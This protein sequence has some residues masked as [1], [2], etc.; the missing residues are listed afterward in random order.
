MDEKTVSSFFTSV[1][2]RLFFFFLSPPPPLHPSVGLALLVLFFSVP[3][4]KQR[5]TFISDEFM[6]LFARTRRRSLR[7]F[8]ILAA[9]TL[10][11][12]EVS[13]LHFFMPDYPCLFVF[14]EADRDFEIKA[15]KPDKAGP[16]DILVF[17]RI[18]KGVN[19]L[20]AVTH[21]ARTWTT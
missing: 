19:L 8:Y 6:P 16:R 2:L 7:S 10:Q 4:K 12:V 21:S 14:R 20:H 5:D 9:R 17:L 3:A 11:L 15:R 18:L 13:G 1:L